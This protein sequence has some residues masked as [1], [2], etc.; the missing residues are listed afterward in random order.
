MGFP[1]S[2]TTNRKKITMMRPRTHAFLA[3]LSIALSVTLLTGAM[4]PTATSAAASRDN[5]NSYT[6]P[7]SPEGRDGNV[8]ESCADPTVLRG[9]APED[10]TWYM[11]CTTDPLNDE[12]LN[13]DGDLAF[14][15]V[16]TMASENLV[17]WT[18]VGDAFD[19]L[20][21]WAEPDAALWA[22]EVVYSDLFDQYYMFVG[23]TDTIATVSGVD[24]CGSDN[25][26]GVAVS[27]SPTGPWLFS[28]EPVIDP[29]QNGEGCNFLWTYDPDVLGDTVSEASVLYYGSYYGGV[30][31]ADVTFSATGA[32][33]DE[34]TS[35]LVALDNKY[36]GSNVVQ[37]DGFYYLFLSATNCCNGA[38]TG[39]SVFVG[40]SADPFGPFVDAQGISL[41]DTQT[42]GTPFL[43]MNGN[44][45]VGTGHNTVFQDA[46][47]AW[48]TIYH[49]VDQRDPFFETATGFTK[50]PA[51]LDAIDWVDGW[52]T[53]NGGRG[54]SDRELFA[55]AG[56]EGEKARPTPR[57]ERQQ[58]PGQLLP[59]YTDEFSGTELSP[60]WSWDWAGDEST[61][62]APTPPASSIVDGVL[63]VPIEATD[64]FA[65]VDTAS[66]L[67]REAPDRDYVVETRVR[68]SVPDEGCCFNFAQAGVLAYGDEDNY[69]KLSNTSI[70]NTRQTE[71]AKEISPVPE[72]WARY[73]NTVV[74]PPSEE[75]T[76][77]RIAVE[78]LQSAASAAAGG[79][80]ERYTAYTSQDGKT[81]V[82]G[83]TWTHAIGD[84][85]RFALAAFGLQDASQKFTAEFDYVRVSKLSRKE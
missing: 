74:G 24:D 11:Y 46:A 78:K 42:G 60:A 20:P 4:V 73:G 10:T 65:D 59:D 13:A 26:I 41:T 9:Q 58:T 44:R 80:T 36:E 56:Q 69:V 63:T 79:D 28:D 40:R 48:W 52:P 15:R 66:V 50:R 37:K 2:T 61:S 23:V 29:R 39:Y 55:P 14:H 54:P 22:P 82:R 62:S 64:L 70:F 21:S 77:L 85:P 16:P 47:G 67:V 31:G 27:A 25:A 7:L 8:V 38:L 71:F 30:F 17:D 51:L 19:T 83:G 57:I 18:Y 6:N 12:D 3:R 53:V 32:S 1:L 45:W 68:V 75:W 72:G 33:V 49:A 81:W 34:S 43:T 84:E 35:T 76:Y 5:P